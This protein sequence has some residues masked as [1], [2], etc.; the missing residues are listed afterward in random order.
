LG[1]ENGGVKGVGGKRRWWWRWGI[2]SGI[3]GDG[4][5]KGVW[6]SDRKWNK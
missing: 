6:G 2:W 4:E 5:W 3:R 1:V